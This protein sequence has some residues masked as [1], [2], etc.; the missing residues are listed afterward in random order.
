MNRLFKSMG[1]AAIDLLS[2]VLFPITIIL[3]I[4]GISMSSIL[5]LFGGVVFLFTIITIDIYNQ[6]DN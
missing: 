6:Q 4:A 2:I 1:I 5:A 3:I